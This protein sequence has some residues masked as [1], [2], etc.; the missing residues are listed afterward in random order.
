M[1]REVFGLWRVSIRQADVVK[2]VIGAELEV[3]KNVVKSLSDSLLLQQKRFAEGKADPP[4]ELAT[5]IKEAK[6]H[7]HDLRNII[8]VMAI[9]AR[10][11]VKR[12]RERN[13]EFEKRKK[14]EGKSMDKPIRPREQGEQRL[15]SLVRE[16]TL[17]A[18]LLRAEHRHSPDV[19]VASMSY[20]MLLRAALWK[21]MNELGWSKLST[22]RARGLLRAHLTELDYTAKVVNA[23]TQ[24]FG[25][26]DNALLRQL[27]LREYSVRGESEPHHE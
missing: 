5:Q 23:A 21:R 11:N 24:P 3:A 8:R 20:A 25:E 6:A 22:D 19:D 15:S 1:G 9:L 14:G 27:G 13:R 26:D 4:R 2:A 10:T 18:D 12:G 7:V 17:T 16:L